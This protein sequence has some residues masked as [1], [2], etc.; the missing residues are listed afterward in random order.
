MNDWQHWANLGLV[1]LSSLLVGLL[2]GAAREL[3]SVKAV[4]WESW[5]QTGK[6]QEKAAEMKKERDEA[7]ERLGAVKAQRGELAEAAIGVAK[8]AQLDALRD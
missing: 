3:R 1:I 5:R 2:I 6:A 7:L 4:C 8:L